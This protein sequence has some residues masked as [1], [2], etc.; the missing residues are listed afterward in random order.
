MT[1]QNLAA[2]Q[3]YCH[4]IT[5]GGK[6]LE[7]TWEGGS[8]SGWFGLLLDGE[9]PIE[10][11]EMQRAILGLVENHLQYGSFAG[12]FSTDGRVAY[13][14]EEKCFIGEDN[15]GGGESDSKACEIEILIPGNMIFDSLEFNIYSDDGIHCSMLLRLKNGPSPMGFQDIQSAIENHICQT[16]Q[17]IVD[18]IE[19]FNGMSDQIIVNRSQVKSVGEMLSYTITELNYW[20]SISETSEVLIPFADLD[21]DGQQI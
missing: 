15:F 12:D 2:I 1:T 5:K 4:E 13:S 20:I 10:L 14:P 16:I 3:A 11:N 8:D 21:S 7:V 9:Q 17:A 6:T 18:D 19:D